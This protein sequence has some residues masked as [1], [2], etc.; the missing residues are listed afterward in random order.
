MNKDPVLDA[1]AKASKGLR[2]TN[3][4]DAP[5]QPF[6]WKDGGEPTPKLL[7][8]QAVGA[9]DKASE[10]TTLDGCFRAVPTEDR[11]RFH[12]LAQVIKEQLSG[13]KA[14]KLGNEA[15]QE[16][17]IVGKTKDGRWAGLKTNVVET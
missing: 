9:A 15:E 2:Y 11:A 7:K 14:Y 3:E 12:K 5:L 10:E 8:K 6:V 16:V 1:L 13:I 17:Y 4:T